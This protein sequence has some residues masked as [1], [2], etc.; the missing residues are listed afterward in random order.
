MLTELACNLVTGG[1][2]LEGLQVL[3]HLEKSCTSDLLPLHYDVVAGRPPPHQVE[4]GSYMDYF[5]GAGENGIRR[6][7]KWE[8]YWVILLGLIK[9]KRLQELLMQRQMIEAHG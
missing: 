9:Y 6:D 1:M 4:S 8:I 3:V 5:V 7:E 2:D